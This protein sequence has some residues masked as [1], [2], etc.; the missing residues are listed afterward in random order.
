MCPTLPPSPPLGYQPS[1]PAVLAVKGYQ[2]YRSGSGCVST[3]QEARGLGV[4]N[5]ATAPGGGAGEEAQL[6]N[7]IKDK[8]R[9]G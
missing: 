3:S 6:P 4:L 8:G 5:E 7:H 2:A 9:K 1:H